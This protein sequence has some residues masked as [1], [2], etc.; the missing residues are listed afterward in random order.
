MTYFWE[1]INIEDFWDKR[2]YF[3]Q[4]RWDVA[5]YCKDCKK[6]VDTHRPDPKG[7]TFVCNICSGKNIA[8]WTTEWLVEMYKIKK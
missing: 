2:Q 5:F 4:K 8:I 3:S 6:I 7:Y 1:L